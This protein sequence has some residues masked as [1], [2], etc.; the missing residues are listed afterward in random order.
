MTRV[1][2]SHKP[3]KK[4]ERP[5]S[6]V[7]NSD[8]YDFP[9]V[10]VALPPGGCELAFNSRMK[11]QQ[12]SKTTRNAAH[13]LNG[14]PRT[15]RDYASLRSLGR[16][17]LPMVDLVLKSLQGVFTPILVQTGQNISVNEIC[18][19]VVEFTRFA[20]AKV[21]LCLNLKRIIHRPASS[22]TNRSPQ[23][24]SKTKEAPAVHAARREESLPIWRSRFEQLET[25]QSESLNGPKSVDS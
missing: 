23:R 16:S 15:R 11:R 13:A 24:T 6:R 18:V 21:R 1:F 10:V 25:P 9:P 4:F 12:S 22:V 19:F 20:P 14:R 5:Q 17:Y 7:Y 3:P 2:E 8:S